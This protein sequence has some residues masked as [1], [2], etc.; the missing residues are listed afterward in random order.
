VM[1]HVQVKLEQL[2]GHVVQGDPTNLACQFHLKKKYKNTDTLGL[3]LKKRHKT[4]KALT[5]VQ[6]LG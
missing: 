3:M 5:I 1:K 4:S 6:L 2:L